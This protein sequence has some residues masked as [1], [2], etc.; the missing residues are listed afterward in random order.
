[1]SLEVCKNTDL[2]W[3]LWSVH[4]I[5][6]SALPFGHDHHSWVRLQTHFGANSCWMPESRTFSSFLFI[7]KL[8]NFWTPTQNL[9]K[10]K[11][12]IKTGS[13]PVSDLSGFSGQA[14]EGRS[15]HHVCNWGRWR[16]RSDLHTVLFRGWSSGSPKAGSQTGSRPLTHSQSLHG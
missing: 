7:T 2:I 13:E 10:Q 6:L 3:N 11:V 5:G 8:T 16:G 12:S 9:T 4:F 15:S 1:M 14:G